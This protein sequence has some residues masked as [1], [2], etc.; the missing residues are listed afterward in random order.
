MLQPVEQCMIPFTKMN[1]K[2]ETPFFLVKIERAQQSMDRS[3]LCSSTRTFEDG[4]LLLVCHATDRTAESRTRKHPC[5]ATTCGLSLV[6][7]CTRPDAAQSEGLLELYNKMEIRKKLPSKPIQLQERPELVPGHLR[8]K[9]LP[10][11]ARDQ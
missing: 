7:R 5:N 11:V 3:V 6:Q 10:A 4:L 9:A 2:P 1:Q 8:R